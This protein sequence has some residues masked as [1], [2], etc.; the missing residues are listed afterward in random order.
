VRLLVTGA[1][2]FLGRSLLPALARDGY[3]VTALLPPG[4][5]HGGLA[6]ARVARGDVTDAGS[7]RG[8][9]DGCAGVVH[10]AGAVG[11]GQTMERCRRVNV[12]GTR[13]VAAEAARAGARRFLHLSSVSVYGRAA[14]VPIDEDFPFRRT[15]DPYGDTKIAAEEVLAERAR[16][17]EL[18]LTVLR[19]VVIYGPGDDKFLPRLVEN[20]RSGRARIVGDGRNRVDALHV[21]DAV[22][23]VLRALREPR[24]VGRAYN[25]SQPGNPTWGEFVPAVAAMLGVPPPRGRLP[26]RAARLL[27]GALEL[28]AR[29]RGGTPRL[30]RYAVDVVGRPYDY[31]ADRARR[32]L[33]FEPRVELLAGVRRWLEDA[34]LARAPA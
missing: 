18:D 20:L 17:G 14:G 7:L 13:H 30:T 25:L 26:W 12:D 24:A 4:E 34:G 3:D 15:G 22:G 9:A 5:P 29:I 21:D 32:E 10:L 2:G 28:D 16:R 6:A 8:V 1:S 11:Y 31:R 33:G 19:P 27:A 23:A